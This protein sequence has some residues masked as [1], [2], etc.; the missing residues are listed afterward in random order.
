M[1]EDYQW[2]ARIL[3]DGLCTDGLVA[4]MLADNPCVDHSI[5]TTDGVSQLMALV[6]NQRTISPEQFRAAYETTPEPTPAAEDSSVDQP[7]WK[8]MEATFLEGRKPGHCDR[9]IRPAL[10]AAT[11]MTRCRSDHVDI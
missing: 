11:A 8:L 6:L 4:D 7:L 2:K 1:T 5:P 3:P 9:W 10:V